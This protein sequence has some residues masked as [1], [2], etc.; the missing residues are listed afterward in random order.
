MSEESKQPQTVEELQAALAK[1][2]AELAKQKTVGEIVSK[3]RLVESEPNHRLG[4][5]VW[6]EHIAAAWIG[7][8][9]KCEL[10]HQKAWRTHED[11]YE[12]DIV[13]Q[14]YFNKKIHDAFTLY[15]EAD[16]NIHKSDKWLSFHHALHTAVGE[17][18]L[19]DEHSY[20]KWDAVNM[21]N[22]STPGVTI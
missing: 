7:F 15:S 11:K 4:F 16:G 22:D 6:K 3:Y 2:N 5:G 19:S 21:W 1:A 13:Y 9:Q 14:S 10:K 17:P 20:K 8:W 12:K 18:D